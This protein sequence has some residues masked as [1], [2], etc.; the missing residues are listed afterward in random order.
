M[1]KYIYLTIIFLILSF[2]ISIAE[3]INDSLYISPL[4]TSSVQSS[5]LF[6]NPAELAHWNNIAGFELDYT[7]PQNAFNGSI[8]LK[9]PDFFL[10]NFA[11]SFEAFGEDFGKNLIWVPETNNR[12]AHFSLTKGGQKYTFTWAKRLD[13][14]TFGA[15]FKYYRYRELDIGNDEHGFGF[16]VG[17]LLHPFERFFIGIVVNDLTNT[18]IFDNDKNHLYDISERIRFSAAFSP[19]NELS[20]TIGAPIDI[21]SEHIDD[22]ETLKKASFS[23]RSIFWKSLEAEVGYNSRDAYASVGYIISDA[24]RL[25]AGMSNDLTIKDGEYK[26][27]FSVSAV[28][29]TRVWTKISKGVLHTKKIFI[30]DK[31]GS[32]PWDL[33]FDLWLGINDNLTTRSFYIDYVD[34]LEAKKHVQ[35]LLSNDG[36]ISIDNK[37]KR[38]II[39][40]FRDNVEEI[41]NALRHFDYKHKDSKWL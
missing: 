8:T 39:T 15:D 13:Y 31:H 4:Y 3:I 5:S 23:I 27:F 35:D 24:I 30:K 14:I 21:F 40:D 7:T 12:E 10:G 29:P 22:R 37:H 16:D 9:T 19:I 1:T 34:V 20:L 6:S 11:L 36:N 2:I 17:L 32:N 41:I 33:L 28:L 38:L 26:T 18:E 25:N